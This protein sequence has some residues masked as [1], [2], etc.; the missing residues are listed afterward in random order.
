MT[1][2]SRQLFEDGSLYT[3]CFK[4]E[5]EGKLLK[6]GKYTIIYAARN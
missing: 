4:I 6:S 1:V 2:E 5:K 3:F